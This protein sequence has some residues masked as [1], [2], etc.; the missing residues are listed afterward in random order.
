MHVGGKAMNILRKYSTHNKTQI[1][2]I[3][4]IAMLLLLILSILVGAVNISIA[5][6]F[7]AFTNGNSSNSRIINFVRLPRS[8]AACLTGIA[9]AMS[10]TILQTV[11]NNPMCSP[12]IIGVNAGAGFFMILTTAFFPSAI[13][14]TPVSAFIGALVAVIIVNTLAR[15]TGASKLAVV[16]SGI[17]VSSVI[18]ALTD[19]VI[20]LVPDAKIAR[21]DFMI[22][23]FSG[24]TM[25]NV[26]FAVP[27]ILIAVVVTLI[28]CVDINVL[29]L[30]DSTASSLGLKVS[31]VR[32]ILLIVA[33]LLAGSAISLGGLIGF[34]GLIVP[35]IAKLLIG[36]DH[37]YL[38]PLSA[39][40]GG[41]FCLLCDIIARVLFAPFELP[42]G[43]IMSLIGA[44]FFIWLILTRKRRAIID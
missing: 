24:V 43:I 32:G 40:L 34:V 4:F 35:H 12:S 8:L 31:T 9:L 14:F 6:I 15:C 23:S 29:S 39:I 36:H 7:K 37:K 16:L 17:A 28:F 33:A 21:V 20:T 30:G 26:L 27:Y 2:I 13:M 19:T 44:P 5:D 18:S 10:G 25:D 38:L 42:V 22:G 3:S 11:L 41:A 1:L